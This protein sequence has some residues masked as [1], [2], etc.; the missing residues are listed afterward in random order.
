MYRVSMGMPPPGV[1]TGGGWAGGTLAT[2]GSVKTIFHTPILPEKILSPPFSPPF[3][4]SHF[5]DIAI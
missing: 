5:W 2:P 4:I 1:V 3:G